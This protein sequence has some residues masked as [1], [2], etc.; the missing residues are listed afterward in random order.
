MDINNKQQQTPE[1]EMSSKRNSMS[2]YVPLHRRTADNNQS[3]SSSEPTVDD[4]GSRRNSTSK[5]RPS[6]I[7]VEASLSSKRSSMQS[8]RPSSNRFSRNSFLTDDD[9]DYVGSRIPFL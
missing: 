3:W 4:M 7:V 5:Y 8:R 9:L 6:D 2:A 1:K